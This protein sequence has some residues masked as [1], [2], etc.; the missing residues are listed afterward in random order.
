[1][2]KHSG[3][4]GIV[5]PWGGLLS[6]FAPMQPLALFFGFHQL[7]VAAEQTVPA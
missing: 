2:V 5:G 4:P 6:G 1:M 3:S 7:E